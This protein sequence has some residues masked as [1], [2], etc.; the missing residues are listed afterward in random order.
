MPYYSFVLLC[1]NKWNLT[2]Q[3]ITT[4]IESLNPSYFE[5]GIEL[6]IV[7]Y[8]S[9]DETKFSLIKMERKY[10]DKLQMKTVH[11]D[12]IIGYPVGINS[13]LEH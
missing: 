11:L 9:V 13:G 3:A 7:N 2:K 1:F 8:G 4:L 10:K 5:W 12:E 6:I